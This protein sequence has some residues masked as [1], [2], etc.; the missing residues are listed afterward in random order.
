MSTHAERYGQLA[1]LFRQAQMPEQT[2][3]LYLLS[4]DEELCGCVTQFISPEKGLDYEAIYNHK[5]M[6]GPENNALAWTAMNLYTHDR[7][8]APSPYDLSRLPAPISELCSMAIQ[9]ARGDYRVQLQELDKKKE[10]LIYPSSWGQEQ[11][12]EGMDR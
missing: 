9:I 8:P 2:A 6:R 3:A 1:A 4:A 10:F 11:P 12:D 5:T 7:F